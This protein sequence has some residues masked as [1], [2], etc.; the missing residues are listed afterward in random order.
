MGSPHD[1]TQIAPSPDADEFAIGAA[2]VDVS[3]I[4]G[5]PVRRVTIVAG[6]GTLK[7]RLK[8][9]GTT[10]RTFSVLTAGSDIVPYEIVAIAGTNNGT[11]GITTIRVSR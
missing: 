9:S 4:G 1:S 3:S 11:S 8:G 10:Y 2:D 7:M 6:S 5:Y